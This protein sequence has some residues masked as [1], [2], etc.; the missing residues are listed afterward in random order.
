MK[1]NCLITEADYWTPNYSDY[2]IA[3]LLCMCPADATKLRNCIRYLLAKRLPCAAVTTL[4][5]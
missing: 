1:L 2:R 5:N 4:G 3:T